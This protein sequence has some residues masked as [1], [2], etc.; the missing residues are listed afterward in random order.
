VESS[1]FVNDLAPLYLDISIDS[2]FT[3]VFGPN[4]I[5]ICLFFLDYV[6][7]VFGV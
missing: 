4:G 1:K 3:W 7:L 5:S 6:I 2:G